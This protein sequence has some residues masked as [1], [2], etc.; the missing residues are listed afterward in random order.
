MSI[1]ETTEEQKDIELYNKALEIIKQYRG[2]DE[3][4]LRIVNSEHIT[5]M[6]INGLFTDVSPD[7]KKRLGQIVGPD[8]IITGK[9]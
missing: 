9:V 4:H 8:N 1:Q 7:L 6:R 5:N 3:V 2:K